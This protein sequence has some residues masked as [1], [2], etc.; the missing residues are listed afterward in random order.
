MTIASWILAAL[1]VAL[2]A[3]ALVG[4]VAGWG[5]EQP[6]RE[7]ISVRE[8]SVRRGGPSG[9]T[10]FVMGGRSMRGGGLHSGK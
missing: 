7:P 2:T 3:G 5:L 10:F 6:T 4:S 9:T 8:G 1:G